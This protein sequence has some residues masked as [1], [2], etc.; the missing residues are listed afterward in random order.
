MAAVSLADVADELYSRTPAEFIAARDEQVR[1]A[2]AAGQRDV[3]AD[4]KKLTRPT[5]SAW[6]V[7]QLARDAPEQMGRLF[8]IGEALLE[9][10]RTLA[11]DRLRELSGERRRVIN[12][13]LPVVV[14]VAR[15]A[16]Q[17]ASQ[18]VLGEVRATLEAALADAQARDAVR[19]G[20]LTRALAYAG[21]GEVDLSA[22]VAVPGPP[23]ERARSGTGSGA[24]KAAGKA[25]QKAVPSARRGAAPRPATS[26]RQGARK[27]V[28]AHREDDAAGE[29]DSG[30]TTADAVRSAAD[31]VSE[32]EAAVDDA[33]Q[34]AA[35]LAE[36][37]QFM[38]RRLAHLERELKRTQQEDDQLAREDSEAQQSLA[39]AE[40][41]LKA[42][43]QLL[44]RARKRAAT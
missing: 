20:R 17:P 19:T 40:R 27:T 43:R 39:A 15:Q 1:L 44:D 35:S 2:R 30:A 7:N 26:A 3:A 4:I 29:L 33:R 16:G 28:A 37:R 12:D 25:G 11:G 6:L 42:A 34:L 31:A 8:E 18:A 13:L 32:A 14:G 9:A 38:T 21:L 10:Q 22:A 36:Q 23:A 41:D 5:A 24:A